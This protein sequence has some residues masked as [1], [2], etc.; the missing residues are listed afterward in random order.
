MAK[1]GSF[2][3]DVEGVFGQANVNCDKHGTFSVKLPQVVANAL[4]IDSELIATTLAILDQDFKEKIRRYKEAKTTE[5]LCIIIFYGA[6]GKYFEDGDGNMFYQAHRN[7]YSVSIRFASGL[8]PSAL[9]F[10]FEVVIRQT[11]DGVPSW[12]QATKGENM[13]PYSKEKFE[14]GKYYKNGSMRSPDNWK[15]IPFS[16][17]ALRTLEITAEKIRQASEIL[18]KFIHQDEKAIEEI[19]KQQKALT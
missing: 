11:V 15:M 7:P 3:Y 9:S 1:V 8:D 5:E 6:N 13:P 17:E 19:L 10:D 2:R 16:E 12:F 14:P 4:G 18:F